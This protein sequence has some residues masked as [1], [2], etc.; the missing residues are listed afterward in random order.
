MVVATPALKIGQ[1]RKSDLTGSIASVSSADFENQPLIRVD[2]ALQAR[3]AGVAV[4]QTSGDLEQDIKLEF[5]VQIPL[6]VTIIRSMW[7]MGL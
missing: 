7:L 2:Q 3:V 5:V 1:V 4:T 6:Q